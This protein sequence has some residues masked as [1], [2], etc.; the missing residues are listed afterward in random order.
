MVHYWLVT[1]KET[2]NYVN[3]IQLYMPGDGCSATDRSAHAD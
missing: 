3:H 1:G 2:L